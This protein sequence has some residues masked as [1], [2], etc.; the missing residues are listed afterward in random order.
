MAVTDLLEVATDEARNELAAIGE[1][2]R[3]PRVYIVWDQPLPD[4]ICN[5]QCA[6]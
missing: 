4:L 6:C 2:S 1:H 5:L 3:T